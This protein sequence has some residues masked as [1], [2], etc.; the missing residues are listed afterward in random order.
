ML[1]KRPAHK[2]KEPI[3]QG[4]WVILHDDVRESVWVKIKGTQKHVIRRFWD[5]DFNYT[6]WEVWISDDVTNSAWGIMEES[7]PKY[8]KEY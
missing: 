3:C 7:D 2:I 4:N 1:L 5:E 8:I 6:S